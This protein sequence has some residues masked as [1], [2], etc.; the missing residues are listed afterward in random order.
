MA[1]WRLIA[2]T[3]LVGLS[4]SS[5]LSPQNRKRLSSSDSNYSNEDSSS[6]QSSADRSSCSTTDISTDR[7]SLSSLKR[8]KSTQNLKALEEQH[9]QKEGKIEDSDVQDLLERLAQI[10]KTNTDPDPEIGLPL[11]DLRVPDDLEL[12]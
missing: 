11:D 12:F 3:L 1:V 7:N 9:T 8:Q 2:V 5:A 6:R 10:C 4:Y